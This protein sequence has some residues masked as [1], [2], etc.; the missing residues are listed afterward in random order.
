MTGT[1][2]SHTL[3]VK[4]FLSYISQSWFRYEEEKDKPELEL[5]IWDCLRDASNCLIDKKPRIQ[6]GGSHPKTRMWCLVAKIDPVPFV[7]LRW[8]NPRSYVLLPYAIPRRL[9]TR[10]SITAIFWS[11][12]SEFLMTKFHIRRGDVLMDLGDDFEGTCEI[13]MGSANIN[14][15]PKDV[16]QS[17]TELASTTNFVSDIISWGLKGDWHCLVLFST[18]YEDAPATTAQ[19]P[20]VTARI[21]SHS[22]LRLHGNSGRSSSLTRIDLHLQ[23]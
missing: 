10:K 21:L 5:S 4:C 17:S 15:K 12:V 19:P 2:S 6:W 20:T 9:N 22:L 16:R 8:R 1:S 18:T 11:T 3:K 14:L 13:T 7:L 23:G